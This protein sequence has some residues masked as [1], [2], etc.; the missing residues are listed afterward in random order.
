MP[1]G[2]AAGGRL[3]PPRYFRGSGAAAAPG[4]AAADGPGPAARRVSAAG[5][6]KISR[7]V[8]GFV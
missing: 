8:W 1:P 4:A 7:L 5:V 2:A 3:A 6:R